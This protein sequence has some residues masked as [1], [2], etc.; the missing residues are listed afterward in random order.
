MS[1]PSAEEAGSLSAFTVCVIGALLSLGFFMFD[2]GH[3]IDTYLRTSGVAENAA[4]IGAQSVT[5]IR[6]GSPR[7]DHRLASNQAREYLRVEEFSGTVRASGSRVTVTVTASWSPR[8]MRVIGDRR[9]V[10]TRTAE[11][12]DQ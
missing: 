1:S 2:S 7:V 4:R 8:L 3:Y 11:V 12:I 5:G 6:A 10:V 9:I